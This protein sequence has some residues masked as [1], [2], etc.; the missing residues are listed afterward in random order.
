MNTTAYEF[1]CG[2]LIENAYEMS[3]SVAELG[4]NAARFTW[5][6]CVRE[7]EDGNPIT[8][9]NR[10]NVRSWVRSFGAWD[11]EEI[12]GWDDTELGALLLQFAAGD[13]REAEGVATDDETGE[14]DWQEYE[15]QAEAGRVSGRLFRDEAGTVWFNFAN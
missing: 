7:A 10:D 5:G 8:D 9:E 4:T 1:E 11:A 12:N 2:H 6:N 15:R 14:I 13:I 3:G